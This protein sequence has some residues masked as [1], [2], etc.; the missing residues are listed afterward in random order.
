MKNLKDIILEKLIINKN[1]KIHEY[2]YFPK[3]KTE[4]REIL[5]K[6]MKER[7][8]TGNYNDIDVSEI[9][10]MSELFNFMD[11]AKFNGNISKW[12]VS[13]VTNMRSMFAN[14]TFEGDISNWDVSNVKEMG[15]MFR[16]SK[17]DGD[18]SNWDVSNVEYMSYMFNG[19]KFSGT[20]G[21]ISNWDVSKVEDMQSMFS[22]SPF[23]TNISKWNPKNIKDKGKVF[24]IFKECPLDYKRPQWYKDI[25][26]K[27]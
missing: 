11:M 18:I 26:K 23:N 9:N 19:S 13:N 8:E 17:F 22:Y 4:L 20:H 15:S 1:I 21:D 7:G 16:Y 5:R 27:S 2:K 24:N 10:D 14:T 12:D 3:D 6:L 25:L